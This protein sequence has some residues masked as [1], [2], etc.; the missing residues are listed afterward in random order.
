MTSTIEQSPTLS[1]QA[2]QQSAEKSLLLDVRTPAE[3]RERHIAGS[4]LLPITRLNPERVRELARGRSA[5]VVICA[6]GHRA[7]M[8]ASKLR[9]AGIESV[10]VLEGGIQAWEDAGMPLLRGKAA[11]SLERQV[12]IA[13][14]TLVA[15]G[16]L[17]AYFV[18]LAWLILPGFIGCGLV[19][20]GITNTCG[21][22]LLL[23]HMPWNK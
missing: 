11:I 3:F 2:L 23:A 14:G 22:A 17:L 19:F 6:S 18:S 20:A 1:P 7:S 5:C 9:K 13:A 15:A 21:M 16:I 10:T 8:A 12:R 4:V